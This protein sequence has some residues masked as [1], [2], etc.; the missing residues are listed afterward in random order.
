MISF[1]R[2]SVHAIKISVEIEKSRP[3]LKELIPLGDVLFVSKDFS[4]F[5][6]Y[7]SMKKAV[8][9]FSSLVQPG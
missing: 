3:I 4:V 8:E 2:Q 7:H 6:G 1:I 9:G 5:S